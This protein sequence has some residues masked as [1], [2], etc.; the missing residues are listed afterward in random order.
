MASI[1]MPTDLASAQRPVG[2]DARRHARACDRACSALREQARALE[3]LAARVDGTFED[4]LAV[5]LR[6]SGRVVTCGMGKSGHV[7]RK[8]AATL[9]CARIPAQFLHPGEAAHGDLGSLTADDV[10]LLVSKSGETAEI[11][12]LLP[13]LRSAG[14]P[15]IALVGEPDST[16]ARAA[17]VVIDVS[18]E[19][20]T[21]PHDRVPTTSA[22]AA[23]AM[24]DALAVAAMVARG[25]TADE[26]AAIHPGAP[27]VAVAARATPSPARSPGRA[28]SRRE[29]G[30]GN[31]TVQ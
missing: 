18:V 29:G 19:R 2:H 1:P 25:V 6:C 4:A 7:A 5:L 9:A 27:T 24:G 20:E 13:Y 28:A 3:R 15:V 16:V 17:T 31:G 8:I 26:L 22:L 21:C 14:V 11:Q 23:M 10:V 12:W 30:N